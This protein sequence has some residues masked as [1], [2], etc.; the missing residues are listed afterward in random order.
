MRHPGALHERLMESKLIPLPPLT[1]TIGVPADLL[2]QRPDIRRAERQ[3]AAQ[4]ARIGMAR[5]ELFP[6]FSLTGSFGYESV[7]TDNLFDA[8]SRVFSLGPSLRWHIFD[9]GRIRQ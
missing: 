1:A 2:R 9:G 6:R 5:A 7:D 3:L 8:D 4:T